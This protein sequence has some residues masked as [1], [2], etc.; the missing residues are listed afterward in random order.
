MTDIPNLEVL[1]AK[2]LQILQDEKRPLISVRNL[3]RHL[4]DTET[5]AA[6][7][8]SALCDFIE[9]HELFNLYRPPDDAPDFIEPAVYLTTRVPTDAE[10]KAHMA[11]ELDN[12]T[13]ALETAHKE[14][15]QNND[16]NRTQQIAALL[17]KA[18]HLRNALR[19]TS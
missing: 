11:I 8:E 7:D 13:S 10:M 9:G 3:L 17:Q 18:D 1:E 6:L 15:Q 19:H 4:N 14:A 16:A 5:F 2:T 12:I